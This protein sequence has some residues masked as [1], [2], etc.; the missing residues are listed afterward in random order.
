LNRKSHV[1]IEIPIINLAGRLTRAGL[2]SVI[3]V[4]LTSSVIWLA[5][6]L[7]E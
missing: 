6:Q 2:V 5:T 4:P 1:G 7:Q 3:R